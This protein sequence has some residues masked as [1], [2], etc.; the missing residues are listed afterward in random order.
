MH[1]AVLGAFKEVERN[2]IL[3]VKDDRDGHLILGRLTGPRDFAST[4]Y[5]FVL[6]RVEDLVRITT[7]QNTVLCTMYYDI[8]Y[9]ARA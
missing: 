7:Y 2:M 5:Y 3:T 4:Q 9:I 8:H 6:V 1:E